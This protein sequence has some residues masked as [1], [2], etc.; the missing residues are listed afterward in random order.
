MCLTLLQEWYDYNLNLFRYDQTPWG[1]SN[2]Y[3]NNPL[4]R[5]HDFN[6]GTCIYELVSSNFDVEIGLFIKIIVRPA[7]RDWACQTERCHL[8]SD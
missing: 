3:G 7:N 6:T 1:S 5:I 4:T 8:L 2:Q